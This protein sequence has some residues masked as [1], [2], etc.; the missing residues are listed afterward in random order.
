M[1]CE[2]RVHVAPASPAAS[3]AS[4][5]S[6]T[7]PSAL[8]PAAAVAPTT[9]VSPSSLLLLSSRLRT[10]YHSAASTSHCLNTTS[11]AAVRLKS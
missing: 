5:T 7:R 3:P 1:T 2:M 4:A 9:R 6:F 8:I 10:P 11:L